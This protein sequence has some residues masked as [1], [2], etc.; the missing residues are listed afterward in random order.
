MFKVSIT[1]NLTVADLY[2]TDVFVDSGIT[3]YEITDLEAQTIINSERMDFW[4]LKNGVIVE[5]EF[6]PAIEKAIKNKEMEKSR[7]IAYEKES[8]PIFFKIQR[9]EATNEQWLAK[10]EEIKIRYPYEE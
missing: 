9:G 5:S 6:K 10:I 2:N 8:D 7:L 3:T 1:E 4:Q